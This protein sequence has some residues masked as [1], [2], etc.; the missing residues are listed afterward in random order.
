[1][2][3]DHRSSSGT[4]PASATATEDMQ[5]LRALARQLARSPAEADDLAQE[6]WLAAEGSTAAPPRSRRA[7]LGGV[8]RNRERML[9]RSEGRRQQR[10]AQAVEAPPSSAADLELH[11]QRVLA[12]LREALDELD[13]DDRA[14]LLSR[15]CD[16]HHAPELAERLGLPASTVRSRLSR[17]TARVRQRL[18][19]RWGGDRQAWAPAV[20]GLPLPARASGPA[21]TEWRKSSMTAVGTKIA[22]VMAAVSVALTGWWVTTGRFGAGD[23]RAPTSAPTDDA[24]ADAEAERTAQLA[25]L[26]ARHQHGPLDRTPAALGGRV[27][28]ADTGEPLGGALVTVTGTS[29][30]AIAPHVV[31]GIDGSFRLEGLPAGRYSVTAAAFGRLPARHDAL[32]LSPGADHHDLRLT[33][34][35]GGNVL[36]GTITDIDGG[37]VEGALV[38]AFRDD[39][40][41]SDRVAYGTL[42]DDEG[43]YRLSLPDGAWDVEAGDVGYSPAKQPV[44]LARGPGHAD[45]VLVP[46]AEIHGRVVERATG[47]PVADA[48][49]GFGRRAQRGSGRSVDSSKPHEAVRT[50]AQ[51]QFVLRPLEP[52]E[53]ALYA[54]APGLGTLAAPRVHAAIGEVVT[55]V[56]VPVDPALEAS[57]FVVD[58]GNPTQG[59]EGVQVIAA[60]PGQDTQHVAVT[61]PDGYFELHGLLPGDHMVMLEGR[62]V[63]ASGLEHHL[64]IEAVDRDDVVFELERGTTVRG[65]VSPPQAGTVSVKGRQESGGFEVMIAARKLAGATATLAADG[66]FTIPSVPPGE[67]KVVAEGEDGSHGELEVTVTDAGP[68]DVEVELSPRASV[69]GVVVDDEGTPLAGLTLRLEKARDPRLPPGP[70]DDLFVVG[71][72]VTAADGS[73]VARGVVPGRHALVVVDGREQPVTLL[74]P[75]AATVEVAERSIGGLELRVEL[76]HGRIAGVVHGPDGQPLPDALVVAAATDAGLM[77]FGPRF[78]SVPA[79]T[80]AEG[81]FVLEGLA[82]RTYDLYAHGPTADVQGSLEAV[83]PGADVTLELEAL[84]TVH[85]VVTS[86]GV[87]VTRFELEGCEIDGRYTVIAADGSFTLA[88]LSPGRCHV[89]VTTDDGAAS[90]TVSLDAG[91]TARVALEL[92]AWGSVEGVLVAAGDGKPLAGVEVVVGRGTGQRK[93]NDVAVASLFG[94]RANVTDASGRFTIEGVGPGRGELAFQLGNTMMSDGQT[95]G[96]HGYAVEPGGRQDLGSIVVLAP[97][98]IPEAERGSLGMEV[99][100]T[101]DEAAGDEGPRPV[102]ITWLEPAG[103]AERAGLRVGDRVVG[104]DDLTEAELGTST[105]L[106]AFRPRRIAAGRGYAVHVD[107]DG[108]RLAVTIVAGPKPG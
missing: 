14:L 35:T 24:E 84:A 46:G 3:V 96:H 48:V 23:D 60:S 30:R 107:R 65:R 47:R 62:G 79:V 73:F 4:Q 97:I 101:G 55:D 29:T 50:D 16:E 27:I 103:P 94:S 80:D 9:R 66:T 105:L 44:H 45:F 90:T 25:E 38:Q 7:W 52:A 54:T 40:A 98:E 5:W 51:G 100:A 83:S 86:A 49:V 34:A 85:G 95:L 11:R 21:L 72:A 31:T 91:S 18:D 89:V 13:E 36:E 56:V 106:A 74:D 70:F 88:R 69:S 6:A 99:K 19:E 67:W 1:M 12:T 102:R 26:R 2:P 63:I 53:Y 81:R 37:P 93:A 59:I 82:P 32:Q 58:A 75:S 41:T 61:E 104:L 108:T 57:G 68:T 42:S 20:L 10:E 92:G 43:R 39:F 22:L 87:P 77:A 64:R 71:T 15:Y 78:R 33:L 76:P 28:A 17:A 8:L